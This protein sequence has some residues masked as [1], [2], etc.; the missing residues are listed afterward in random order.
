MWQGA[1]VE[2]TIARGVLP[3]QRTPLI[4][5]DQLV[6]QAL[7]LLR[8]GGTSLLTLT[9]PGGVGKTRVAIEV[10]R[11]AREYYFDDLCFVSL[12]GIRDATDVAPA[13][14]RA[15]GVPATGELAPLELVERQLGERE[16]LLVLD[17]FEHLTAAAPQVTGLLTSCPGVAVLV[18]SR[19]ALHLSGETELGV[20]TLG[21]PPRHGPPLGA[22]EAVAYSAVALFV[23]RAL[24]RRPDFRIDAANAPTIASICTR[25]DGLPLAIE[26][27]AARVK[28]L[29]PAAILAR[30]GSR[31]QLLVD[32]PTDRPER[33]RT[34]L[35]TIAWSYDL[36]S[37]Q[38][39][40]L[41]ARLSVFVGGCTV[42][43][44]AATTTVNISAPD[45]QFDVFASLV[46]KS[47]VLRDGGSGQARFALLESV[48]EFAAGRLAATGATAAAARAHARYFLAFAEQAQACL[49]GPEQSGWFE[50]LEDDRENLRAAMRFLLADGQADAAARLACSLERFWY[51]RG[52][53]ADGR[54][55]LEAALDADVGDAAE[56]SRALR[57]TAMLT[58]YMGNLAQAHE[59]AR[60]AVVQA[61]EADDERGAAGAL[62]CLGFCASMR[63]D[64]AESSRAYQQGIAGWR[65][66]GEPALLSEA[67]AQYGVSAMIEG[68]AVT[69]EAAGRESLALA[70]ELGDTE[71]VAYALTS[72]SAALLATTL[73]DETA[74]LRAEKEGEGLLQEALEASRAV[75]NRRHTSRALYGLGLI[76]Q[77]RG[78]PAQARVLIEE[79]IAIVTE[80]GD[81][82]FLTACVLALATVNQAEGRPEATAELLGAAAA[83]QADIGMP[84]PPLLTA[85]D[86]RLTAAS[87]AEL[88][89]RPW[90]AHWDKGRSSPVQ[91]TLEAVRPTPPPAPATAVDGTRLTH[92]EG[93]ILRLVAQGLSDADV[94]A[95]LVVSR[96]TVHAHLRS[97]YRKLDVRSRSAA[98]RYAIQHG[99]G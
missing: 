88:G 51:V 11:R 62:V 19:W 45:E 10:A 33:Q 13:I 8:S 95:A 21:V 90:T 34:L 52:D 71:G 48:R 87:C 49:R 66:L 77:R 23:Q 37:E 70:R 69:A 3:I 20:P 17:E 27:A 68:D 9:G 56:R 55:W 7:G 38:E 54:A 26:L 94:A 16:L 47:M 92:R 80:F 29:D 31:L 12:G 76:A 59:L 58:S 28:L 93:E 18:T 24:A 82:W 85:H 81:R 50:R 1:V 84:L 60:A 42:D 75:G 61:R 97:V 44:V 98:T 5:R 99:L 67:L 6:E 64:H 91:D 89:V 32:G 78:A 86:A 4:G 73:F 74:G 15:L 72:L 40:E 79:A 53:L 39:Q 30:M 41:L 96:R 36:L 14:A 65:R 22:Q 2:A 83:L 43:S 25:L 46:D 57:V 63:G 35:N